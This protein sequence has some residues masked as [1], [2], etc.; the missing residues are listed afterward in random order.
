MHTSLSTSSKMPCRSSWRH[1]TLA[2]QL[3]LAAG[4]AA[5]TGVST[6]EPAG[7]AVVIAPPASAP[8]VPPAA[9]PV[10]LPN[11][12]D[13]MK[14]A[15]LGDF[16][17]GERASL[18]IAAQMAKL[19]ATFPFE[20]V[21]LL[22]DNI[23]GSENQLDYETKFER[24]Y[25]PLLDAEVKFYGSLGNHDTRNQRFYKLF[26]MDGK[27]Y[28]SFK[29]ALTKSVR[30]YAL[31][32]TNMDPD[33]L[34]WVEEELKKTTDEWKI[35]FFH[36]PLFSSARAHGSDLPLRRV[37]APIFV[38]YNVSLVLQGHDHVYERV[39]PQ[40]GIVYFVAGSGGK[41]RPGDLNR[42]SGFTAKGYDRDL[43]FMAAEIIDDNLYFNAISR[44]GAVVDSG[45]VMRRQPP[46]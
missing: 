1:L 20:F 34:T 21:V 37:L 46:K 43:V 27:L 9:A 45:I 14:F 22:G 5:C 41:L 38:R 15:I 8:A 16:G 33:Q 26:N 4:L 42:N 31:E 44:T 28:Y 6:S 13:S 40:E 35:M 11:Q 18:D 2:L 17:T 12:K 24:P 29:P 10:A 30:F 25:K 32:T 23:Y 7:P 36:H 19:H 39:Q 3:A